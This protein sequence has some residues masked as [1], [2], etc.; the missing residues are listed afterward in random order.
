MNQSDFINER[1]V[2]ELVATDTSNALKTGADLISEGWPHQVF[3]DL[4]VPPE[5]L[6]PVV[7]AGTVLGLVSAAASAETS[8][9]QG[10]PA[11]AGLTDGTATQ[12]G[13]VPMC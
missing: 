10:T 3:A 12:I 6:P 2:G 13:A 11:I 7:R 1:L 8:L 4:G 5:I 9:P